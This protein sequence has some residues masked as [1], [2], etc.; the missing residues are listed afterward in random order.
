MENEFLDKRSPR[1]QHIL[2]QLKKGAPPEMV[3][4]ALTRSLAKSLQSI[5]KKRSFDF[6]G[7]FRAVCDGNGVVAFNGFAAQHDYARLLAVQN[8][9]GPQNPVTVAKKFLENA[10]NVILDNVRIDALGLRPEFSSIESFESFREKA[11]HSAAP[12]LQKLAFQIANNPDRAPILR[13][14]KDVSKQ[15]R[16]NKIDLLNLSIMRKKKEDRNDPA[17]F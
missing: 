16:G 11:I 14:R 4:A 2:L 1:V 9:Q 6:G 10:S 12:V 13:T 5:I 3:G 15:A 17:K 8:S 7:S